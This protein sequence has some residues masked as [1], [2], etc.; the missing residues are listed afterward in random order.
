MIHNIKHQIK[1]W[2]KHEKVR[3][4]VDWSK[5]YHFPGSGGVAIFD[6]LQFIYYETQKDS[7]VTRANSIAFS[8]FLSIF[9]FIIFLFTLLPYLPFTADYT[10]MISQST[11]KLLPKNA[12]V[13]IMNIIVDITHIRRDGL[14]SLGFFFAMFF[15]SN[16]ML[17]LMQGFDKT[18]KA[19][20]RNRTI[21]LKHGIALL[22]TALLGI[23]L[24]FSIV[25][26]IMGQDFFGLV[27]EVVHNDQVT[28]FLYTAMRWITAF[29]MLYL[30]INII[31]YFGPSL[32]KRLP[33]INPGCIVASLLSLLS[34]FLFAYFVNSFGQYNQLYGS[35]GALIVVLLWLKINAFILLAGFELNAAI[36]VNRDLKLAGQ[37]ANEAHMNKSL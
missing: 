4:V 27:K 5:K 24:L 8:L 29:V 7:I 11:A 15:S 10:N 6:V 20:F 37:L 23:L 30:G 12:H 25:L 18:Y 33:F 14:L 35:I 17:T 31:Y 9:P 16:G 13:Y 21:F 19:S 32:R 22:L 26:L 34:S 2:H 28:L 3:Q 36:V 1:N